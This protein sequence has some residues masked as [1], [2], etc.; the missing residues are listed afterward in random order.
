LADSSLIFGDELTR[1]ATSDALDGD[2]DALS[3]D[4]APERFE[5]RNA[6]AIGIHRTLLSTVFMD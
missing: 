6:T 2:A 5:A 1:L 3:V 4:C